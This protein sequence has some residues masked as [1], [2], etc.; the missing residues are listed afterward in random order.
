MAVR[1]G[2]QATLTQEPQVLFRNQLL[3]KCRLTVTAIAGESGVLL[4]VKPRIG[5]PP[6]GADF[7]ETT[8]ATISFA[9]SLIGADILGKAPAG[10]GSLDIVYD[11]RTRADA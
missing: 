5:F 11:V 8:E 3:E 4:R 6:R 9:Q 1:T 7:V 2:L 10:V